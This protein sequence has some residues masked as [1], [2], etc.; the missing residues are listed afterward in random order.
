M[1]G[2]A[3]VLRYHDRVTSLRSIALALLLALL[4]GPALLDPCLF[5]CHDQTLADSAVP[6]CHEVASH[7]GTSLAGTSACGHEHDVM[8]ADAV[9]DVRAAVFAPPLAPAVLPHAVAAPAPLMSIGAWSRPDSPSSSGQ[10]ALDLP[11]RL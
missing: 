2:T 8:S 11:L 1:D 4:G 7:D 3:G 10:R 5:D 6:P 9:V